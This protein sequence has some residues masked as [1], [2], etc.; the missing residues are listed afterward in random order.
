MPLSLSSVNLATLAIGSFL[1][2]MYDVLFAISMYLL[3]RRHTATNPS[4]KA[5]SVLK[6][7]VFLSAIVLFLVVTGHWTMIVYRAFLAFI[8][9]QNGCEAEPFYLDNARLTYRALNIFCQASI[10]IGDALIKFLA[11]VVESAGIYAVWVILFSVTYETNSNLASFFLETAPAV[12]GIVNA[13]IHTRVGLG[14]TSEPNQ[15]STDPTHFC[16]AEHEC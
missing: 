2:G 16:G 6:S 4:R 9:F 13:L 1:Y 14:W 15:G 3:L 10:V 8:S 7:V 12:V 5:A 11:I